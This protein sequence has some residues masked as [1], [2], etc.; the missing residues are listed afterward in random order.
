MAVG[1]KRTIEA[2]GVSGALRNRNLYRVATTALAITTGFVAPLVELVIVFL[3]DIIGYFRKQQ[4][5]TQIHEQLIGTAIP[6]FKTKLRSELG[7]SFAEQVNTLINEAAALIDEQ[8][9]TKQ[10]EIAAAEQAKKNR[11]AGY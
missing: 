6:S 11:V 1:L 4:Q 9:K 8:I 3:P 2:Q 10:D 7:D 5:K